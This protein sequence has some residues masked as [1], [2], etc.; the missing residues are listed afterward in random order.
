MKL[1]DL[2]FFFSEAFCSMFRSRLMIFIAFASMAISLF[3]FG[4][5]LIFNQNM[6]H[7]SNNLL[8][9][10]ELKIFFQPQIS[11]LESKALVQ[12][13]QKLDGIKSITFINK[14]EAWEAFKKRHKQLPLSHYT[15]NNPLPHALLVQLNSTQ[16]MEHLTGF[17]NTKDAL[18]EDVVY[19]SR[20]AKKMESLAKS[21]QFGGWVLVSFLFVSTILIIIN[22]IRLTI[23]ARKEE[24]D[25]MHLIGAHKSFILGPFLIEGLCI[26][27]LGS[28]VS[29][30]SLKFVY[31]V[32]LAKIKLHMPFIPIVSETITLISI[33]T[34]IGIIGLFIG[35]FSSYISVQQLLKKAR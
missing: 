3:L 8:N 12:D 14:D 26:G 28:L 29:I 18:V 10:L 5:V 34:L 21:I 2:S 24:I 16:N 33:Y 4:M 31:S 20:L 13:I 22:T 15:Q 19:G 23:L 35:L 7:F 27:F 30:I 32:L 17:L 11:A 6:A 25:I 1:S 9:K